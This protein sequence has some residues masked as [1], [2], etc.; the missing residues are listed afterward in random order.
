MMDTD[1][2]FQKSNE[3]ILKAKFD[4]YSHA[5]DRWNGIDGQKKAKS[6]KKVRLWFWFSVHFI[7]LYSF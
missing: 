7:L 1:C 5:N 6:E 3:E 2:D 4:Q